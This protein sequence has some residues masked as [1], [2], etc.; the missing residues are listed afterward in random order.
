MRLRLLLVFMLVRTYDSPDDPDRKP[1]EPLLTAP[2]GQ[3]VDK[4]FSVYETTLRSLVP[5]CK[6][7]P[8]KGKS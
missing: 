6:K 4:T 8:K 5:I 7:P 1:F 3:F 2:G